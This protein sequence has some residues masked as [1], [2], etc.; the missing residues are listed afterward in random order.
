V[1]SLTY[2]APIYG[3]PKVDYKWVKEAMGLPSSIDL[4]SPMA[5]GIFTSTADDEG[6]VDLLDSGGVPDLLFVSVSG[7][8]VC[9]ASLFCEYLSVSYGISSG[10][11]LSCASCL[12]PGGVSSCY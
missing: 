12:N 1:R 6:G 4:V 7:F 8:F 3:G 9:K 2:M 10:L 11:T 5:L